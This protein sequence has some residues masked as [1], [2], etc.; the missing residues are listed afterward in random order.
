[1]GTPM[2]KVIFGQCRRWFAGGQAAQGICAVRGRRPGYCT[3]SMVDVRLDFKR[4]PTP[5]PCSAPR[6]HRRLRRNETCMLDMALK[7]KRC[8]F[9]RNEACG[10]CS[11]H[12]KWP[13]CRQVD[14]GAHFRSGT[15]ALALLEE[16]L[17]AMRLTRSAASGHNRSPRGHSRC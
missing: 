15:A 16:L 9:Y 5:A 14:A 6:R 1:M 4:L 8:A 17:G 10:K 11:A 12:K 2:S 7:N 13:I 3:A